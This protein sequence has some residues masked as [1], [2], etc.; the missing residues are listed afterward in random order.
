MEFINKSGK[1]LRRV[2]KARYEGKDMIHCTSAF[3]G[4]VASEEA[5]KLLTNIFQPLDYAMMY[6]GISGAAAS[7][8]IDMK[9]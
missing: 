9:E 3:V 2:L 5:V 7:F 6:N 4:G 8:K 1:I